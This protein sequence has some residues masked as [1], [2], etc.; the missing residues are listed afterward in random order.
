MSDGSTDAAAEEVDELHYNV[1]RVAGAD[2]CAA[3]FVQA[4][5]ENAFRLVRLDDDTVVEACAVCQ[6]GRA[7]EDDDPFIAQRERM[8]AEGRS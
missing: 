4:G 6:R 5:E 1:Q 8:L 7:L 2:V 3:C